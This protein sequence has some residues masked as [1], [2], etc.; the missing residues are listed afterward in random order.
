MLMHKNLDHY[1]NYL[2]VLIEKPEC[3]E[4]NVII[5]FFFKNKSNLQVLDIE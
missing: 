4:K 1:V 3:G 5:L 2:N